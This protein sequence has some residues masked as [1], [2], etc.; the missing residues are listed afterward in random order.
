M[1]VQFMYNNELALK[2]SGLDSP[3]LHVPQAEADIRFKLLVD[4]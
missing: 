1:K 2:N 4:F 3:L